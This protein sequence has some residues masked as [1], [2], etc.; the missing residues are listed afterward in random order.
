MAARRVPDRRDD[1]ALLGLLEKI[2]CRAGED[3]VENEIVGI[4]GRQ[5][6]HLYFQAV[7]A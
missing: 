6:D 7:P 4:E 2:A 3:R 5:H 1:L